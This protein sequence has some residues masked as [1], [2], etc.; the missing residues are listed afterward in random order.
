MCLFRQI[1]VSGR[2]T[3]LGEFQVIQYL[4]P[5]HLNND[6][7]CSKAY[8]VLIRLIFMHC[9]GMGAWIKRRESQDWRLRYEN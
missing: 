5:H 8:R 4:P 9:M 2:V 7:I 1:F 6:L 3:K